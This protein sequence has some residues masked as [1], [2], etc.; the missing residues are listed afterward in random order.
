M[1]LAACSIIEDDT[2]ASM[3]K[4]GKGD[5]LAFLIIKRTFCSPVTS[6]GMRYCRVLKESHSKRDSSDQ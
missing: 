2:V 1:M 6:I 4:K 3:R 5:I